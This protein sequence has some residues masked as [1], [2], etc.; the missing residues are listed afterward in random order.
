MSLRLIAI[1]LY[2]LR[3]K[4]DDLEKALAEAP[5][6]QQKLL[7]LKWQQAKTERDE[8]QQMLDARLARGDGRKQ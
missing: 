1:D 7:K 3:R 2:R 8:M 6:D 4:V 5:P